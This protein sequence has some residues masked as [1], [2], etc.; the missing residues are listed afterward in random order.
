MGLAGKQ[1]GR[2]TESRC[3]VTV[4]T[5]TAPPPPSQLPPTE[6]HGDGVLRQTSRIPCFFNNLYIQNTAS[7]MRVIRGLVSAAFLWSTSR[8]LCAG[9]NVTAALSDYTTSDP[10]TTCFIVRARPA[11]RTKYCRVKTTITSFYVVIEQQRLCVLKRNVEKHSTAT[12][13]HNRQKNVSRWSF[14][15]D[16]M[17]QYLSTVEGYDKYLIS[18]IHFPI[19]VLMNCWP[20]NS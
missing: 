19:F 10:Y 17:E 12:W 14:V 9:H 13:T 16:C 11:W 6:K 8:P 2:Q 4:N 5:T 7:H 20:L 15:S 1:K 3:H 18:L